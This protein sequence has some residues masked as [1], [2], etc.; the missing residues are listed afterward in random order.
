MR[1][2]DI[3]CTV[4]ET[5][6]RDADVERLSWVKGRRICTS[7]GKRTLHRAVAN[8]G[9]GAFVWGSWKREGSKGHCEFLGVQATVTDKDGNEVPYREGDGRILH[10]DPRFGYEAAR[11]AEARSEHSR[12]GGKPML[13]PGR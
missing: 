6:E 11:E 13:L 2:K 4:C 12:R 5:V 1:L 7:C 9:C 8:G 10:D 3:Y